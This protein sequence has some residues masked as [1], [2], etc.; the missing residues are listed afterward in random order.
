MTRT[1]RPQPAAAVTPANAFIGKTH[2][3][4]GEELEAAL[5]HAAKA[6]WDRL[7]SRM[8]KEHGLEVWEWNSYSPKAGW[9]VRL[10]RA[11]RNILYLAPCEGCFRAA[12]VLG[13]KAV[14]AARVSA[15]PPE[16]IRTLDQATRYAEGTALR[17]M[18]NGPK[19]LD[20]LV[21]LARIRAGKLRALSGGPLFGVAAE[22]VAHGGEQLVGEIGFAARAKRS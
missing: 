15:L 8:A 2:A 10:K 12:L 18:V 19:D 20:A 6:L 16:V 14:Q 7:L 4:T 22:F 1:T 21:Q 17:L 11:K 5:G 9:S 13:D 3:P